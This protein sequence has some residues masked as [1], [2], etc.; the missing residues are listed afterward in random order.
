LIFNNFHLKRALTLLAILVFWGC[1]GSHYQWYSGTFEEAKASAGSKLIL[2]KFY[3][4][5]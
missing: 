4:D 1:Q 3:T 2:L 5:T